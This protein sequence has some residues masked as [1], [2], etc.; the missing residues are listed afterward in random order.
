[1]EQDGRIM[2]T[3]Q[4]LAD[5]HAKGIFLWVEGDKLRYRAPLGALPPE[6]RSQ[7]AQRKAEII[8]FL[9]AGAEAPQAIPIAPRGGLLPLSFAEEGL[10]L[11]DRLRPGMTVWNMQSGL[12][13]RGAL[14]VSALRASLNALL[15][16][17]ETLRTCFKWRE[18][19]AVREV[20]PE[21]TVDLSPLA[22]G[23]SADPDAEITR[24]AMEEEKRAFDLSRA[25][26]FRIRLLK[27]AEEDQVFLF[28]VHHIISDATSNRIFYRDLL[29]L[30]R[31]HA[32]GRAPALE[33]LPIQYT[34]YAAWVRTLDVQSM[35]AHLDYW[36]TKLAGLEIQ[37][38][39][40]DK[41]RPEERSFRGAKQRI[42][43]DR[44]LTEALREL[45]KQEHATV[46]MLL[47]AGFKVLLYRY[48]ASVDIAVGTAMAG[49]NR[50]ELENLVG[51]FINILPLRT[52]LSD[53]PSF[54]ELL[55]RVREVCLQAYQ[56]QD[57]PFE[58]LVEELN[59]S[60]G[61]SRNP[62]F[63]V[64]FDVVNMPSLPGEVRGLALDFLPRP[65][66]TARYEIVVRAPETADG[67]QLSIDYAVDLFSRA[68][69]A[70]MLE[71]Y[72]Y[73]LEQV[74]EDPDRGID[75][76]S[77]LTAAARKVLPD[78]IAPLDSDWIGPAH[79]LFSQ[80]AKKQPNAI[81]VADWRERWTYGE[82]DRRSNQLARYLRTNGIGQ[83]D[84]VAVW[85]QRDAG[86]VWA[87]M[88]VL[89]AGGAFFILDPSHPQ[90]RLKEYWDAVRPRALI[91][92]PH[93]DPKQEEVD[94]VFSGITEDCRIQLPTLA[95]AHS[96]GLLQ[97]YPQEELKLP[98]AAD[99][100]ACVIFTSGST[101]KPKGV[102]GR[103]GPLTH[104]LPWIE[105]TFE[106]C[107]E[108]RFSA[109]AGLSS[110]ILQR[111]IFTALSLGATLFI[112]DPAALGTSGKLDSWFTDNAI[113][114]AHLTSAMAQVLDDSAR[115]RIPTVRRVFFAGDLL[116]MRDVERLH[117][118]MP[119][120]QIINFYASSESQR[121]SGYKILSLET[122]CRAKDIPPLGHGVEGVQLLVVNG[123]NQLAGVGEIGEIWVRS[124]HL[125]RGYLG[126]RGLTADR[127]ITN[128]FSG[129]DRDRI[130]RTGEQGRFLPSGEVEFAGRAENQASIRGFR[131]EIGEVESA[132]ARHP[133]VR[134]AV[135]AAREDGAGDKRLI[136]YAVPKR[137]PAPT[138]SELRAFLSQRLPDYMVPSA[139]V[140]LNQL[141]LTPNG[142]IA[143]DQ[144]PQLDQRRPQLQ[145][146]Y[147]APRNRVEILL[148]EIWAEILNLDRVGIHDNFFDL[149]GHSILAVRL[150]VEVERKFRKRI[151]AATPF[152]APTISHMARVISEASEAQRASLIAVQPNG[153]RPPFFCVHGEN[154]SV[155][156]RYL[157]ADQ[158]FYGLA[159]HF[160]GKKIR[161]ARIEDI[162]SRY[163]E[164]M[165]TV[166][167]RGPFFL[168]GY[169]IGA[170]IA[171][172]MAEQLR[173]RQQEVALLALIGAAGPRTI[174]GA[175]A[176]SCDD[177]RL[178]GR[179]FGAIRHPRRLWETASA[180]LLDCVNALTCHAYLFSGRV[181]PP[182]LHNFYIDKIVHRK[183]YGPAVRRYEPKPYRGR[184]T[185]FEPED[186]S[187]Q[188]WPWERL[189][190]GGIDV[191]RIPGDRPQLMAEPNVSLLAARLRACLDKARDSGL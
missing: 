159:Q 183:L 82:L 45:C 101:G 92:L 125:A 136:A 96:G 43:L 68:R 54:R 12:R 142:K 134:E 78:P 181:L 162:A 32:G 57:M 51:M 1:M 93:A 115:Q 70:E 3:T 131:I 144:L 67:L 40:A 50:P 190:Q 150:A 118:W 87:L 47:V 2:T 132:V 113:T 147:S 81:A 65:Q 19:K 107:G 110:N 126:D 73:L 169:A 108:D 165:Q 157:G 180:A 31:A 88:G 185:I 99:D 58:K 109:L 6:L 122:D 46:F 49:R 20:E 127:F 116:K 100:L 77:L 128:P 23:P 149:G 95:A 124:P 5:L 8:S 79:E 94:A 60:R 130:F 39:P 91:T 26:L 133:A 102:M 17:Q 137:E 22:L 175:A 114:V 138:T 105:R 172:E 36:R 69:I 186:V 16:R 10:W 151:S 155:L 76:Y 14:D 187:D 184:I 75:E 160:T 135:V 152:M 61:L 178:Y 63:Q 173:Q 56:H 42:N 38:I 120:A 25:P 85:G 189:A 163:I 44:A 53:Q 143:R 37:E 170:L 106:L 24:I 74:V 112:P 179:R 123:R 129:D 117:K 34:D 158:P 103:H 188:P 182:E 15:Q 171:L 154:D 104:F 97:E 72:K 59:P 4:L 62:F 27:V 80:Q 167:A 13:I 55:R 29:A 9:H 148:A 7:L 11:M 176:W 139:F 28:T 35:P 48:T 153:Y 166:Q 177:A 156:A 164:E 90:Q 174:N 21:L 33:D 111:E 41:R 89:K 146:E 18:G 83:E 141:P 52:D 191:H 71:H 30:Y 121:A 84:I 168:G 66:D 161:F 98:A 86:L 119:A 145:Y 64:L 140:F